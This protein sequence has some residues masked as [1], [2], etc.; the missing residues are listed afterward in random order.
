MLLEYVKGTQFSLKHHSQFQES[1]LRDRIADDPRILGMGPLRLVDMERRHPHAGRLDLLLQQGQQRR[2][3]VEIMLGRLDESHLVRAL[4]YWDAERLESPSYEYVAV[5]AAEELPPRL[6]RVLGLLRDTL[7]LVVLQMIATRVGGQF[8]LHFS[9]VLEGPGRIRPRPVV[10]HPSGRPAWE[11]KGCAAAVATL[12]ACLSLL[13]EIDLRFHLDYQRNSVAVLPAPG[14]PP[15][16]V[17]FPKRH[18]LRLEIQ[19]LHLGAFWAQCAAADWQALEAER[20]LHAVQ[21]MLFPGDVARKRAS[22]RRVLAAAHQAASADGVARPAPHSASKRS[23][24]RAL[25]DTVARS[26]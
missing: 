9:R 8:S 25:C 6:L 15:L 26:E 11:E 17:F 24:P 16:L 13:P 7:P 22:L 2:Y 4:E 18:F 20:L 3:V 5:L 21:I 10:V 1:W 19:P 12:D 23:C 14:A